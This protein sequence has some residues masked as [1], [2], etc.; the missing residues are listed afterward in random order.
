MYHRDYKIVEDVYGKLIVTS[1]DEY[2][3]EYIGII[4]K[5]LGKDKTVDVCINYHLEEALFDFDGNSSKKINTPADVHVFE[6]SDECSKLNK[7]EMEMI[8]SI[9]ARFLSL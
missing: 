2:E 4:F 7:K 6:V 9:A 1:G 8:H 3:Y 5:Y